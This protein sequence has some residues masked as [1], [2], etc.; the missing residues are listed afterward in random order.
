MG[1]T[2]SCFFLQEKPVARTSVI[3]NTINAL[4]HLDIPFSTSFLLSKKN[5]LKISIV[6]PLTLQADLIIFYLS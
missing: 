6:K 4:I 2:S 5:N 3:T 1:G